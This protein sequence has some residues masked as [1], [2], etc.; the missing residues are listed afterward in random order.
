M[1]IDKPVTPA[2]P[3]GIYTEIWTDTQQERFFQIPVEF[4]LTPG[5]LELVHPSGQTIQVDE[6]HAIALEVTRD[7]AVQVP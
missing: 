1:T 7:T 5:P 4:A 6:D 2:A 3:E